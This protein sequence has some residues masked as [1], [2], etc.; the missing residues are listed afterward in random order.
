LAGLPNPKERDV[1]FG[2]GV[3]ERRTDHVAIEADRSIEIANGEVDF[4]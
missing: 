2:Y 1:W 4:P 3:P